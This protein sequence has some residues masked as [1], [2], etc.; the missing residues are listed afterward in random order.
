MSERKVD[1]LLSCI[2]KEKPLFIQTHNYPDHDAVACAFGLHRFLLHHNIQATMCYVGEMQSASLLAMIEKLEIFIVPASQANITEDSQIILVDGFIGNTNVESLSA[3]EIGVIDHHDPPQEPKV[4]FHDIRTEYGS[5]SS[6]IYE[7][8][9]A[10]G[11]EVPENVATALL[12]G[13]M[14]DTDFMTRAVS[15]HDLNAFYH[16]FE[17][18]DWVTG[19][20]LLKNSLSKKDVPTFQD[21][22]KACEYEGD[23]VFVFLP[24]DCSAELTGI[25]A[26]FFLRMREIHFV[27]LG[28]PGEKQYKISIR[29]EDP[30]RPASVVVRKA[31]QGIGFGGGHIH[32]GGGV[33]PYERLPEFQKLKQSFLSSMKNKSY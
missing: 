26:D 31:L 6:I 4:Q 3:T 12:I 18:G 19:S 9:T 13:L 22:L 32:M 17:V 8:Y 16:L 29:S 11:V 30:S 10:A 20:Y 14:M 2:D 27:V 23:T 15:I 21:A 7:Y 1:Q 25:L 24:N 28:V 5:C 33:I